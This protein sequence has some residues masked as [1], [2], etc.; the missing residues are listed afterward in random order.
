MKKIKILILEDNLERQEQFKN[1]LIKHDV[2][3]ADSA[4]DTI[5]LLTNEKWDVLFIDHDLGGQVY[6]PSGENTGYEVAKFLEAN[7]QHMPKNIIVHSL[8]SVGAK[9][10]LAALPNAIHIPFV[11]TEKKLKEIGLC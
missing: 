9:N 1:N 5:N 6:V 3:L 11:W 7:K 8:N 10:I 2:E 4:K